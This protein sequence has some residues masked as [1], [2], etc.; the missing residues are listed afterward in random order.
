MKEAPFGASLLVTLPNLF[1]GGR[2]RHNPAAS[3]RPKQYTAYGRLGQEYRGFAPRPQDKAWG[4]QQAGLRRA[5][6][7]FA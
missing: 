5:C 7:S 1:L 2:P 3:N 4:R 6:D